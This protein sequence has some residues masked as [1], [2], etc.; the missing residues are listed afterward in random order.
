MLVVRAGLQWEATQAGPVLARSRSG[1]TGHG[2]DHIA[3]VYTNPGPEHAPDKEPVRDLDIA[4]SAPCMRPSQ[5][6]SGTRTW[7]L[8]GCPLLAGTL[9][10]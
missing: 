8:A 10:S 9:P 1:S 2:A 3:A 5:R 7:V 4:E 6:A